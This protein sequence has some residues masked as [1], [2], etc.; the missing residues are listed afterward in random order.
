M[1][2]YLSERILFKRYF[3]RRRSIWTEV[4]KYDSYQDL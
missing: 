4:A 1:S 3:V 2:V